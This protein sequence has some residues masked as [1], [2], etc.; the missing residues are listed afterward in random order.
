[1]IE[2]RDCESLY[3]PVY[4][5]DLKPVEEARARET[6]I[7][8]MDSALSAVTGRDVKGFFEHTGYEAL[9]Q[10]LLPTP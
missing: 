1:M 9:G 2:T 10:K 5:P 4:S 7:W 6:V 8:A 3:L